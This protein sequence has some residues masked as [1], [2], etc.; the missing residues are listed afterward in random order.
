MA[1]EVVRLNILMSKETAK[2]VDM[3]AQKYITKTEGVRRA[4]ATLS[5]LEDEIAKDGAVQVVR[6]DGNIIQLK[7]M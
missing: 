5:Y 4:I 6:S 1:D 2:Q 3:L 7:F